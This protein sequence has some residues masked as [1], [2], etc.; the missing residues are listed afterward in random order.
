MT[1][2][3]VERPADLTLAEFV[4]VVLCRVADVI[5][6]LPYAR[7]SGRSTVIPVLLAEAGSLADA[8]LD[9]VD[10]YLRREGVD[11]APLYRWSTPL[12]TTLVAEWLRGAAAGQAVST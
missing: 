4:A 3:A 11:S 1:A 7:V 2:P 10:T 12:S 9:V 5:E 8:A 6:A